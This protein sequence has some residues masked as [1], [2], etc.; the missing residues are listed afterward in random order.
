MHEPYHGKGMDKT[1]FWGILL[2]MIL[3]QTE[4]VK[5]P[6]ASLVSTPSPTVGPYASEAAETNDCDC[7]ALVW[8]SGSWINGSSQTQ[9]PPMRLRPYLH[10]CAVVDL[11][12][13]HLR[14]AFFEAWQASWM[15]LNPRPPCIFIVLT[16]QSTHT[17]Y[18]AC[19]NNSRGCASRPPLPH[20][21]PLGR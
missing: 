6:A 4:M 15:R 13:W 8:S 20:P 10:A 17:A 21:D 18:T 5:R 9:P 19:N 3:V 14:F 7:D 16:R 11:W 12:M 2:G 1:L